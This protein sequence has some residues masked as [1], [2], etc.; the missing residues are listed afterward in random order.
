MYVCCIRSN[1]FP[2]AQDPTLLSWGVGDHARCVCVL[3]RA[4]DG[5]GSHPLTTVE[6]VALEKWLRTQGDPGAV[7]SRDG[8]EYDVVFSRHFAIDQGYLMAVLLSRS[9]EIGCYVGGSVIQ[10]ELTQRY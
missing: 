9:R 5:K 10:V 7:V 3:L 2:G 1:F 6:R 8:P 4:I